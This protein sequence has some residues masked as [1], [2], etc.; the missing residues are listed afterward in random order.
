MCKDQ[1]RSKGHVINEENT[2][3]HTLFNGKMTIKGKKTNSNK[4]K[5]VKQNFWKNTMD[6]IG[7]CKGVES[8][9]KYKTRPHQRGP[10]C[11]IA[12]P[13]GVKQ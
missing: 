13:K 8:I 11:L 6:F 2:S 4:I 10:V 9:A 5:W 12:I 3:L 7:P 1:M